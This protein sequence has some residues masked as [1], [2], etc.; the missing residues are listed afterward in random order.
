MGHSQG[1]AFLWWVG[2]RTVVEELHVCCRPD[3]AI[4]NHVTLDKNLASVSYLGLV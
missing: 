4:Y 3:F 2:S 1:E